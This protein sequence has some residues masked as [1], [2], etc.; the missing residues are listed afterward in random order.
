MTKSGF[1]ARFS[2]P[3]VVLKE[4]NGTGAKPFTVRLFHSRHLAG[5]TGAREKTT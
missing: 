3:K 4:A 1:K 2:S 5:L